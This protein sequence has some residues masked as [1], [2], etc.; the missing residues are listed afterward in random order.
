VN[1]T[2]SVKVTWP[3]VHAFRL[4]RHHLLRRAPRSGLL[5]VASAIGGA[6]AQVM[7]AAELQLATRSQAKVEDVREALWTDRTLVKTWLV[8]GTLHLIPASDLPLYSAAMRNL[9]WAPAWFKW[10]RMTEREL[11]SLIAAMGDALTDRPMTKEELTAR[12]GPG[13]PKHVREAISGSWGSLLKP[14]ARRGLL[15]FGPSRGTNVTLVNPRLWLRSWKDL[16]TDDATVELGRR[17]LRAYGPATKR[18]FIRWFGY[19]RRGRGDPWPALAEELV[20][21]D[22]EGTRLQLLAKDVRALTKTAAAPSVQLLAPFDPYL[23]GHSSRDHLF[24]KV[25]RWKVS[26]VAGWISAVVLVDGRVEGTWTH[27]RSGDALVVNVTPFAPLSAG[28]RRE[29]GARAQELATALGLASADVRIPTAA[30]RDN[31]GDGSVQR[32]R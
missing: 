15:A 31:R 25:H 10:L 24:D 12:V 18:D 19:L 26:R 29:V 5:D 2:A 28:T 7:S 9:T 11:D 30:K 21:V 3:Q 17:Y 20:D 13:R 32:R 22:V 16:D 6:Q 1:A 4:A 8:R 23:M 27:V 14:A